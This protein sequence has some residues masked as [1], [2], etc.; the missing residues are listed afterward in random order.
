MVEEVV[1]KVER[2]PNL[3]AESMAY[4]RTAGARHEVPA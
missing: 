2:K 4:I 3:N 1:T